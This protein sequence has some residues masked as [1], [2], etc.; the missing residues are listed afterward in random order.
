MNTATAT[1]AP[2]VPGAHG[3]NPTPPVVAIQ[4]AGPAPD[5]PAEPG[6]A[7][8]PRSAFPRRPEEAAPVEAVPVEAVSEGRDEGSKEGVGSPR[9][10]SD[11]EPADARW[12]SGSESVE[13]GWPSMPASEPSGRLPSAA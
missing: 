5:A 4:T 10:P 11:P 6:N 7:G 2:Q 9:W 8:A 12:A 3:P 13:I 1:N